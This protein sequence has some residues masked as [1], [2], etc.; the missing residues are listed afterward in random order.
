VDS[1][2]HEVE[3]VAASDNSGEVS[4]PEQEAPLPIRGFLTDIISEG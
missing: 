2:D 1:E 3:N 4:L